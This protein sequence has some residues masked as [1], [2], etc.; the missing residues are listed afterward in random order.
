M[1]I[2]C[3]RL[4]HQRCH[5][6]SVESAR[7]IADKRDLM[8]KMG[9]KSFLTQVLRARSINQ[10][11]PVLLLF[12]TLLLFC[13]ASQGGASES[14][15]L[16]RQAAFS[17][18]DAVDADGI[19]FR[20]AMGNLRRNWNHSRWSWA[21]FSEPIDLSSFHAVAL[22]V[23]S[24][25]PRRDVGVYIALRQQDGTW[26]GQHWACDL[27]AETNRG[28]AHFS[29]FATPDFH[30]PPQ[31][32]WQSPSGRFQAQAITAVA[33]GVLNPL[34]VGDV[35]FRVRSLQAVALEQAA[36]P[37]E[38]IKVSGDLLDFNNTTMLPA[39]V[40]GGFNL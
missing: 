19:S 40:F 13:S 32:R 15:D 24:P 6:R 10:G 5:T 2:C 17:H 7:R 20:F 39:G 28:L 14:L 12:I 16:L 33:I 29:D 27:S 1:P 34:G 35:R 37:A 23:E 11:L 22:E 4:V 36:A 38:V 21:E 18:T 30:A 8:K 25:E 26:Y 3:E 9:G 31:G